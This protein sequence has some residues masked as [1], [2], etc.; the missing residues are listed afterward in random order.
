MA[1]SV[2][3]PQFTMHMVVMDSELLKA[4]LMT[5][6]FLSPVLSVVGICVSSLGSYPKLTTSSG[7]RLCVS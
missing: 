7:L 4:E 3:W 2:E 5:V 1:A 6:K